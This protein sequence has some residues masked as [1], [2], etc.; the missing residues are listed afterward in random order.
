MRPRRAPGPV[1]CAVLG[2]ALLTACATPPHEGAVPDEVLFAQ[3]ADLPG[4]SSAEIALQTGVDT[5]TRYSG[6]LVA[7]PG[8]DALCALEQATGIMQF[9]RDVPAIL[10]IEQGDVLYVVDD[11]LDGQ[12]REE[13]FGPRPSAPRERAV[14][15]ACTSTEALDRAGARPL[16]REISGEPRADASPGTPGTGR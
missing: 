14:V 4:I 11:V 13:R 7:T 9:G 6:R 15:P 10:T 8:A 12:S 5:G 3:I 2:V 16:G 1:R